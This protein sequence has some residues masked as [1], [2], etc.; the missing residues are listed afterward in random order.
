MMTKLRRILLFCGIA[1][2]AVVVFMIFKSGK[3]SAPDKKDPSS[4]PPP[5]R[6]FEEWRK[7]WEK[8]R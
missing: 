3:L 5:S 2:L 4:L 1:F 7:Q 6:E 8:Q